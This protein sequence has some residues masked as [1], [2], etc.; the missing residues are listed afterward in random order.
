MFLNDNK[1][2]PL[3]KKVLFFA[4][5][6]FWFGLLDYKPYVNSFRID[7][8]FSYVFYLYFFII[9]QTLGIVH[10]A[11][12]GI[13][14]ILPCPQ[15][16]VALNGTIFQL[17][18]PFGAGYYYLKKGNKLLW[19]VGLFFLG[20][21]MK[22][23]AWYMADSRKNGLHVT[24]QNSFLGVDGN[25]DFYYIFDKMGLLQYDIIIGTLVGLIANLLLLY[26]LM[27]IFFN[28]FVSKKNT[29]K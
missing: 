29:A 5:L 18:F 25:H 10:E 7:S 8:T 15:F 9:N 14:Y 6:A 26:S 3:A 4:L 17:A 12:H 16:L 24:A 28:A 21:S 23:T 1:N 20:F 22:Y 27:W 13:C 19:H 11:G 2:T